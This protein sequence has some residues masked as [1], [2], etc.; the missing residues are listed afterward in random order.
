MEWHAG[1]SLS[2]TVFTLAYVHHLADLD[3]EYIPT[4]RVAVDGASP[5]PELSSVVLKAYVMGLLKCC[6]LSWRELSKHNVQDVS[7]HPLHFLI[8][9]NIRP[10]YRQKI[11][12][13]KNVKYPCLKGCPSKASQRYSK[14]LWTG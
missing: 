9:V 1:N 4:H 2:Q 10:P 3:V 14:R 7:V 6:D 5:I 11:G 12:K 13:V 8:P